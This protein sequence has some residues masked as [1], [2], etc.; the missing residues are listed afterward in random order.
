M[1]TYKKPWIEHPDRMLF[2]RARAFV[3][4]DGFAD[5]LMGLGIVEEMRDLLPDAPEIEGAGSKRL[6]AFANEPETIDA[7]AEAA[8]SDLLDENF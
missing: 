6:A 1:N 2:N 7:P 5:A 8:P 3:L 4:R